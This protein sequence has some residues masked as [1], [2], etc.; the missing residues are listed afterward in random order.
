VRCLKRLGRRF[1]WPSVSAVNE[2]RSP[3]KKSLDCLG[4]CAGEMPLTATDT[5]R[6]VTHFH[7]GVLGVPFPSSRNTRK[8]E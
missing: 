5:M 6:G 4:Q 7:T 3:Q 2:R 8:S 1:D